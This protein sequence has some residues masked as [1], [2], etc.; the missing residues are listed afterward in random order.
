MND[1]KPSSNP[2]HRFFWLLFIVAMGCF[3]AYNLYQALKSFGIIE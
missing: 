1:E 2:R 3:G